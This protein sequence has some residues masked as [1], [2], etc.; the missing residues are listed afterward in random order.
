VVKGEKQAEAENWEKGQ[1]LANKSH[2]PR[3]PLSP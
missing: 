2:E 1:F 3:T